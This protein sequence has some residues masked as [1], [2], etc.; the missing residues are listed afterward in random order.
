MA[1]T[2]NNIARCGTAR[3]GLAVLSYGAVAY[4]AEGSAAASG[5]AG[6]Y[7]T[8]KAVASGSAAIS[9]ASAVV[10]AAYKIT[11]APDAIDLSGTSPYPIIYTPSCSGGANIPDQAA[12]VAADYLPPEA[13]GDDPLATSGSPVYAPLYAV[14]GSGGAAFSALSAEFW[15]TFIGSVA[16]SVIA[17]GIASAIRATYL[18]IDTSGRAQFASDSEAPVI[19]AIDTKGLPVFL[20]TFDGDVRLNLTADGGAITIWGGQPDMDGGL[21]TAVHISLFTATGW[22]GNALALDYEDVG[23]TLEAVLAAPLTNQTRLDVEAAARSALAWL[24]DTGIASSVEVAASIPSI[25]QLTLAITIREPAKAPQLFRY[26]I[27]WQTQ[28]ITMEA[29]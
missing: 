15:P 13:S 19:F 16:G 26:G 22:W 25:G 10:A 14:A 11:A 20:R 7:A 3:T 2:L 6:S 12:D 29:A 28:R 5:V 24:T 9:S 23:S 21:S 18:G 1:L 4:T 8:Y 27:N 17:S